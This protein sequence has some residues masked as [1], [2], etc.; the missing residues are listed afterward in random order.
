LH[1]FL[2]SPTLITVEGQNGVEFVLAMP[3]TANASHAGML[4]LPFSSLTS[5]Q[6]PLKTK[7]DSK[8]QNG[9]SAFTVIYTVPF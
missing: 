5:K 7:L 6:A 1:S 2:T 8:E 9:N 3:K 4:S